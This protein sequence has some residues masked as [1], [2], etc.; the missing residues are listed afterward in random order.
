MKQMVSTALMTIL[1]NL[2]HLIIPCTEVLRSGA[3]FRL[4]KTHTVFKRSERFE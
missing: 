2:L 4:E 3:Q 1:R